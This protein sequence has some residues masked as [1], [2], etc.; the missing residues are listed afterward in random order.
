MKPVTVSELELQLRMAYT[1]LQLRKADT[2]L[3]NKP[4]SI[5][6]PSIIEVKTDGKLVI[7]HLKSES[8]KK[9]MQDNDNA[10]EGWILALKNLVYQNSK[11]S[12]EFDREDNTD[13][14]H[15]QRFLMRLWVFNSLFGSESSNPWFGLSSTAQAWLSADCK[16][17]KLRGSE[18]LLCNG[19]KGNRKRKASDEKDLDKMTEDDIELRLCYSEDYY[20]KDKVC[21]KETFEMKKIC[22]QFP[23]GIF[24]NEVSRADGFALFPGGKACVD[25]IGDDESEVC[26]IFELKKT[27]NIPMG[28]LSELLFYTVIVRDIAAEKIIPGDKTT[29]SGCYDP[30]HLIGKKLINACFLAPRFHPLLLESIIDNLNDA[31]NDLQ[32]RDQLSTVIF[33]KAILYQEDND[34]KFCIRRN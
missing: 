25:L 2:S 22:R 23:V 30:N 32:Q 13:D 5:R 12:V 19:G 8:I 29:D 3:T 21:L 20:E 26:W 28:I 27:S 15:Y 34:D 24:E 16:Y 17:I 14:K 33:H 4:R 7:L 31:F 9:N 10:F 1:E 18:K 11:F 6:W